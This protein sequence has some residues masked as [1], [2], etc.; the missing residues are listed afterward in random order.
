VVTRDLKFAVV[1]ASNAI[2][3]YLRLLTSAHIR[4]DPESY[5]PF[6][7]DPDTAE[8]MA[9]RDFCERFVEATGKEAGQSQTQYIFTIIS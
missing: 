4:T 7:F 8:P 1:P 9:P 3:V 5:E 6:L 2:V